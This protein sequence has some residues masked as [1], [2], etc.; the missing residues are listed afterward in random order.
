MFGHDEVRPDLFTL[1]VLAI[2]DFRIGQT[3]CTD[4]HSLPNISANTMHFHE[5][6][7]VGLIAF[8]ARTPS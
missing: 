1:S 7:T 6:A 2:S 4:V 8:S 5:Q 3:K